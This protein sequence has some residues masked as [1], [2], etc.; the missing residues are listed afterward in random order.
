MIKI[1]G[2]LVL[3][4]EVLAMLIYIPL[5]VKRNEGLVLFARLTIA[6]MVVLVA[7]HAMGKV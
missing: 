7:L 5:Y 1:C 6:S 4:M 2:V 3:I